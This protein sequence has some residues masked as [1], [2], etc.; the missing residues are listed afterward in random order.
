MRTTSWRR[1]IVGRRGA[2]LILLG[3]TWITL[4]LG[5]IYEPAAYVRE[6]FH[7]RTYPPARVLLWIGTGAVAILCALHRR[8]RDYGFPLLYLM[9]T[10]RLVSYAVGWAAGYS[11]GWVGMA[12]YAAL[13][14][15]I[16]IVAGWPEPPPPPPPPE[17]REGR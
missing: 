17:T 16:V 14:G 12:Y 10:F 15:L 9:P 1:P 11:R 7:L 8:T 6:L 13:V 4:G 5:I 3:L 2:V